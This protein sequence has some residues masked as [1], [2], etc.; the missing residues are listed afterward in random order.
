MS[1]CYE[2][3]EQLR[4]FKTELKKAEARLSK[5]KAK[6]RK[7][8]KEKSE[9]QHAD[10]EAGVETGHDVAFWAFQVRKAQR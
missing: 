10:W 7:S 1:K 8:W 9:D 5:A 6:S 3:D 2:I 4:R